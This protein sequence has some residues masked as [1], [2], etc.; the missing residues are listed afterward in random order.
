MQRPAR[1]VNM[2]RRRRATV[3]GV[4]PLF[5]AEHASGAAWDARRAPMRPAQLPHHS[6]PPGGSAR[7]AAMAATPPSPRAPPLP[8]S[9]RRLRESDGRV[10]PQSLSLKV[11]AAE[12]V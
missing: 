11:S 4:A 2:N 8:R 9:D 3:A 12:P 10:T 6:P 5:F 1:A 7:T